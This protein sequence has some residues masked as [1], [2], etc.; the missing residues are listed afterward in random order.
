VFLFLNTDDF[1]RDH[2]D[3]LARGVKFVETPREE[4]YG[5]VAVFEDLYGNKWDL[6][7]PRKPGSA[8]VG[9]IPTKFE[10]DGFFISTEPGLLDLDFVCQGLKESYWAKDRPREVIEESIRNSVCFGVYESA[11]NR[12]VGFARIV[13]DKAT[14]SWICDVF[15]DGD[16]RKRGLGTWLMSCVAS[17]PLVVNSNSLLGTRDAHGL[18]GKFGYERAELMRRPGSP[19]GSG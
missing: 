3:M 4:D 15:I 9:A 2:R 19:K 11:G 5:T 13:T 1:H 16:Y 18:Y 10:R 17:H 14:F 8:K 6:V 7:E 12:Q